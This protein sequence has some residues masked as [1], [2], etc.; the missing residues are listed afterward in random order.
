MDRSTLL[1]LQQQVISEQA[2][3][4]QSLAEVRESREAVVLS[5]V[6]E[7]WELSEGV[8][9]MEVEVEE[10]GNERERIWADICQG[11]KY[12]G[13]AK[14]NEG[15][16]RLAVVEDRVRQCRGRAHDPVN[17]SSGPVSILRLRLLP[18]D[19]RAH[20]SHDSLPEVEHDSNASV[21]CCTYTIFGYEKQCNVICMA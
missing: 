14:M 16:V 9:D 18:S 7:V 10:E 8:V 6:V 19:S 5:V 2:E 17:I 13:L 12:T 20:D 3:L 1:Y 4:E 15:R 11:K 21:G